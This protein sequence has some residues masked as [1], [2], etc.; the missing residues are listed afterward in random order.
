MELNLPFMARTF[1]QVLGAIPVTLEIVVVALALALPLAFFM[2]L[3]R[4][5]RVKGISQVVTVYV[6]FIRGTPIVLQILMLYSLLPSLLNVMAKKSGWQVNVFE[7]NPIIYAFAVFAINSTAG[8]SEIFR[9]ALITVD[10]GQREAALAAGLSRFDAYRR[11]II[12]QALVAALPNLCNFTIGLVKSTSL[13]FIMTVKDVTAVA[14]IAASYGY[15]YIEAYLDIFLV[16]IIICGILQWLFK[17]AEGYFGR[18]RR[19][20]N[21]IRQ[22]LA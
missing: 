20:E 3:A 1:V 5:H 19:Q 7:L 10:R 15:N 14:K 22:R 13:A 11:I 4:I 6:S 18:F 16:Y 21:V 9:S 12:P 8:L 2:A 17:R